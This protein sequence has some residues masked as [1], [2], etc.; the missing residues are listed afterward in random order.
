MNFYY[1]LNRDINTW[2]IINRIL[3]LFNIDVAGSNSRQDQHVWWTI[4]RWVI[5]RIESLSML[6]S[7]INI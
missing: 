1:D 4:C 2:S 6:I 7:T 5:M 3:S